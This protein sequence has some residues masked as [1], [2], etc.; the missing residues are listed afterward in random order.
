MSV[1]LLLSLIFSVTLLFP[2][3]NNPQSQIVYLM[4]VEI[5]FLH[6][7]IHLETKEITFSMA[8]MKKSMENSIIN[9]IS[10]SRTAT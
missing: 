9:K 7:E 8:K 3:S 4:I 1:N 2:R 5:C 10:L 6:V